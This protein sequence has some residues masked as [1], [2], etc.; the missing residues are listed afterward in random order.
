MQIACIASDAD[1][2]AVLPEWTALWRRVGAA[3]PFQ[4][5]GWLMAWW[6]RFGSGMPRILTA[7]AAGELVGVLPLYRLDEPECRKLL[8]IGIGL[9]D[10]FDAL[11]DPMRGEAAGILLAAI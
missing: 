10:Y 11:V 4:F 3:T 1:L 2:S 8:P 7:R 6:R 5:P 9:S